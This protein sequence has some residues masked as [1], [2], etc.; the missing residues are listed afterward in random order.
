MLQN[1]KAANLLSVSIRKA[2]SLNRRQPWRLRGGTHD[3]GFKVVTRGGKRV[4][5][6]DPEE[7]GLMQFCLCRK[8]EGATI[9]TICNEV[10]ARFAALENRRPLAYAFQKFTPQHVQ[11]RD[12]QG[13][14]STG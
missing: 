1:T 12:R 13:T 3:W 4:R 2:K 5:V 10:E 8:D 9:R 11:G 6:S 7:R 14:T